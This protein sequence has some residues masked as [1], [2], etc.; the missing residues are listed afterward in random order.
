MPRRVTLITAIAFLFPVAAHAQFVEPD[1][2]VLQ[3]WT[4]TGTF[5]WAVADM[6]DI[7]G[8]GVREAIIGAPTFG[9]SPRTAGRVFVRSGRTGAILFTFTGTV[10]NAQ[11][12]YAIADAG[13]VNGDGVS[14][15]IAGAPLFGKGRAQVFSGADGSVIWTIDGEVS[16]DTFGSAVCSA[17]DIDG[18]GHSDF[19]VGAPAHASSTGRV[20]IYSGAT[21]LL[22]RSYDGTSG[23]RF[24]VGIALAGDINHDGKPDIIV[25]A[26]HGG[27]SPFGRAYVYS[28]A[29]GSLL[30]PPLTPDTATTSAFGVFFV[31]GVGDVNAD[32]TP[33]LYVGDYND[34]T[35]GAGS[36]K[37]YVFSGADGSLLYTF[38]G[39][40]GAGLGPG[41]GAG[42]I[43][44]D[45]HADLIIGSY[46]SSAGGPTAGKI[47]V[48]SGADGSVLRTIT[49]TIAGS[50]LGFDAV[51]LGDVNGDCS[52]DFLCSAANGNRVYVI[53]G[54]PI[55]IPGDLNCDCQVNTS[56]IAPFVLALLDPAAY[57][58]AN[59]SCDI[60]RADLNGDTL[61]DG[62]D[63]AEL[64]RR[65]VP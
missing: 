11:L 17:G 53:A 60:H 65:L 7:D 32:G 30:L 25:G 63:V 8:D 56:D 27:T 20:Y 57:Q 64:V 12:G 33:D 18:D 39:P 16:G 34:S 24:G 38:I 59:P 37:A 28:G 19:A 5:G 35:N 23:S 6:A 55:P 46:T 45:G 26:P 47:E 22:I 4:G 49:H 3:N 15:I 41:R 40:A 31:A 48:Y 43:N 52:P 1:V 50:Q 61:I 51:G 54:S 44:R 21:G 62:S 10:A 58:L 2:T 9:T 36:G 29:D 14:D 13:D 42:D